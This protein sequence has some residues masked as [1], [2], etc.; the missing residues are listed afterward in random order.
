[1]EVFDKGLADEITECGNVAVIV[2]DDAEKAVPMAKALCDGGVKVLEPTLRTPAALDAIK[3]IRTEVPEAIIGAG[4]LLTPEQ[5]ERAHVAGARF[6]V[7]PGLN[8]SVVKKAIELGMSFAPGVMTPSDV[9]AA[10]TLGCNV[11]KFF[12]A[13]AAGGVKMLKSLSAPYKH[14]GLRYIPTG[15]LNAENMTDYLMNSVVAAAGGSWVA[16]RSAIESEDW[17]T[18]REHAAKARQ[19]VRAVR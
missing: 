16:P 4:T 13:E 2:I 9:E 5:L 15:G 8:P 18:I 14:L 1:M 11:L 17:P 3:A 6:A 7:S 19:I 12:P 10:L